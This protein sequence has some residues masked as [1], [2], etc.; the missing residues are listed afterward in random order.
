MQRGDIWWAALPDPAGSAPGGRRPVIILQADQ[1]T[2]S[3]INTVV[4]VI[5]T[6]NLNLAK[7]PGNVSLPQKATGLPRASVANVSQIITV[8]KMV[9][10]EQA[11]T[12]TAKLLA[13]VEAGVRLVLGL[14]D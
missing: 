9:L 1:F 11:G 14:A 2:Q 4:V 6:S 10:T 13:R 12:L 7:A 3:R 8:D 5:V